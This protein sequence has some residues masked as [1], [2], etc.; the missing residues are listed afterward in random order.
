[1][2]EDLSMA[3]DTAKY[4]AL[5]E[6]IKG[7]DAEGLHGACEQLVLSYKDVPAEPLLALKEQLH[8][9]DMGHREAY[10]EEVLISIAEK[11][12]DPFLAIATEPG[13]P[14]WGV[15]VEVLSMVGAPEYLDMFI[16]L[17][18]LAPRRGRLDLVRAIGRYTG[19]KVVDALAHYLKEEDEPLFFE[20]LMALR[21]DG[22]P[23]AMKALREALEVKRREASPDAVVIER[24]LKELE[25]PGEAG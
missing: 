4:E 7:G 20:A 10:V 24:V 23:E 6:A 13:H 18:P 8:R 16:K 25:K 22:G 12:P 11:R 15:A 9:L 3:F 17:L 2:R 5:I 19:P 21:A 1:M 14:L